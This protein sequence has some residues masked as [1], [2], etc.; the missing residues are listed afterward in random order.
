M[1]KSTLYQYGTLA[2]LVP[3]LFKGTK[4]I[5]SL[6]SHGDTG[7]GTGDG[8]DGELVVLDGQPYQ[9]DGS[10]NVNKLSED[11]MVPFAD[12]HFADYKDLFELK[13]FINPQK[14]EE[15]VLSKLNYNNIF[16]SFRLHGNFDKIVTRS[17]DKQTEPYPKLV[18]CADKQNEFHGEN[19]VGTLIGYY[20]PQ[21]FNG[22]AVGGFHLHFLADDLSIGGHV[23]DFK[24]NNGM[25]KVQP[26][27]NLEQ[28]FPT[29][30]KEF[31]QHDFSKDDVNGAIS[32]AE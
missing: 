6:L 16:F 12:V 30:S 24:V 21:I 18:E 23:L 4:S 3:G 7:I 27:N 31:M 17:V 11:F 32:K 29:D 10:G 26:F 19:K 9:I 25:V 5:V 1:S 13:D 2:L 15:T 22:P 14:L 8:L 28:V 20:A